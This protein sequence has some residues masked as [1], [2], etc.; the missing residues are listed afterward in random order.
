MQNFTKEQI[1]DLMDQTIQITAS[2]NEGETTRDIMA[3]LYVENMQDKTPEQGLAVADKILETV[4][5]FDTEYALARE[6]L[7]RY[8]NNF[9]DKV[10]QGKTLCE[11]CNYWLKL[12]AAITAAGEDLTTGTINR[13]QIVAELEALQISEEE[14]TEEIAQQLRQQAFEALKNSGVLLSGLK[15]LEAALNEMDTADAAAGLL[16]NL[17]NREVEY[18]AIM[19]MLAYTKVK[20]GELDNIPVEMT[21]AQI[22]T[23]VCTAVEQANI[24]EGVANGSIMVEI[25]TV[26]LEMLAAIT[27][28]MFLADMFVVGYVATTTLLPALLA[29]PACRIF[30]FGLFYFAGQCILDHK[31]EIKS[32]VKSVLL[33]IKNVH[34]GLKAI[35]CYVFTKLIPN[36]LRQARKLWTRLTH[37]N[38]AAPTPGDEEVETEDEDDDEFLE[39]RLAPAT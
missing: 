2:I 13:E 23:C 39:A 10:E 24:A 29:I 37:R 28:V 26:L 5:K 33:C 6:D 3:R 34:E 7:D 21:A 14:A 19:S 25:A 9:Q 16:I 8:I 32:A 31:D 38:P 22:T 11:R 27:V 20:N 35:V 17:G 36:A 4:K 1:A 30:A 12:A 18:R 15:E